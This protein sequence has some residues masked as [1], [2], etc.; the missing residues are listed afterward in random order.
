METGIYDDSDEVPWLIDMRELFDS[1]N[2]MVSK[3][4]VMVNDLFAIFKS[5]FVLISCSPS[6]RWRYF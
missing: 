1:G 5:T 4:Q 6:S 3:L 2:E